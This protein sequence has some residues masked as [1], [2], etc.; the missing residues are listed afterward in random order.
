MPEKISGLQIIGFYENS[1]L[2]ERGL[3]EGDWILEYQG[4]KVIN[5]KQLL[6][7]EKKY[8][9]ASN[10]VIRVRRGERQEF[11]QILP[12]EMGIYVAER[13]S[14]SEVLPDAKLIGKVERLESKT[15]M[16]NTFFGALSTLLRSLSIDIDQVLLQGLSAYP[17]RIQFQ[18]S[19]SPQQVDPTVG[20]DCSK[21]LF[22]NL[23][24]SVASYYENDSSNTRHQAIIASIDNE[25]PVLA[26]NLR[27]DNDWGIVT[28]YQRQR[29]DLFCRTYQ[30]KTFNYGLAT[31]IPDRIIV[32]TEKPSRK[33]D[34]KFA[35][36]F[37]KSIETGYKILST[38][39]L[40]EFYA[41]NLAIEKWID[42]LSDQEYF[43]K[44]TDE[45]FQADCNTNLI[46]FIH[47]HN[48]F[49]TASQYLDKFIDV[50]PD[51]NEHLKRLIKFYNAE[52]KILLDSQKLIP[53]DPLKAR[54]HWT[55]NIRKN[56]ISALV[57]I[58][59]KNKEI[60][61]VMEK[62]PILEK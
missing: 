3:Q 36:E 19:P 7:L 23:G 25:I 28:G 35:E 20:F 61:A 22:E 5:E 16:E 24:W 30:D 26:Y 17:F 1:Q 27:G 42:W 8:Q 34:A 41:G 38:D 21:Y 32:F 12:G 18:A 15:G 51:S 58:H 6:D 44:L 53:R 49:S 40:K 52:S 14:D 45:Q 33:I 50:F 62:L 43:A 31:Q 13:E 60:L 54:K 46:F 48:Q 39:H 37:V 2:A 55:Q 59:K 10:I 47:Y 56:E 11:F 57:K 9:Y 4:V 29:K